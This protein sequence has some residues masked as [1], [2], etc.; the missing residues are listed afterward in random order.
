VAGLRFSFVTYNLWNTERWPEREPA[1]RGFLREIAPDILAVQEL[2]AETRLVLDEEL[3]G[4]RRVDDPF[5]GWTR[6]G[7]I[8]WSDD[9]FELVEYGAEDVGIKERFRRLFWVRLRAKDTGRTLVASTAHFT[10][11]GHKDEVETFVNPRPV[12]AQRAA[13]ALARIAPGDEP[14]FIVGDFNESTHV[15][16]VLRAGGF[17]DSFRGAAKPTHPAVP[18]AKGTPQ[19]LDWQFYRGPVRVM[20]SEVIDFFAGDIAPSDHK[21]VLTVY[22]IR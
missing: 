21:P 20:A 2:R 9:L 11:S 6:E 10:W 12:Q 5:E 3:S 16:R 22:E 4:H 19:V 13:E 18:T 7:N 14:V 15:V 17:K 1:L 8:Y